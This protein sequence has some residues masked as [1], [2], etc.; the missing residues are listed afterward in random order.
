MIG[1]RELEEFCYS[2]NLLKR[3]AGYIGKFWFEWLA[4]AVAV[5]VPLGLLGLGAVSAGTNFHF[6]IEPTATSVPFISLSLVTSVTG[7]MWCF[8]LEEPP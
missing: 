2:D 3:A 5:G 4:T 7:V 6:G 1:K 8:T